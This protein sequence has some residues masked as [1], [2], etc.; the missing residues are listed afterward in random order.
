[1]PMPMLIEVRPLHAYRLWLRYA[2]GMAGEVDLSHLVGRGVFRI[3]ET[4]GIFESVAIGAHGEIAW[5]GD[6]DLC[7]DAL[8]LRLAR[9][10]PHEVF[11]ALIGMPP[12]A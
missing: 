5:G 2:D 1:M 12:R 10:A 11:P 8:Y 6:V 4:P 3:W 9:K 7:P